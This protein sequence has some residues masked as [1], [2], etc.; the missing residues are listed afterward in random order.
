[1]IGWIKTDTSTLV[2]TSYIIEITIIKAD[3]AYHVDARLVGGR[4]VRLTTRASQ[5]DA[6]EQVDEWL[7]LT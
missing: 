1:M 2:N 4:T 7:V 3:G 5:R 6:E